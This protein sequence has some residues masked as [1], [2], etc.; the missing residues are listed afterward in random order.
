MLLSQS[1]FADFTSKPIVDARE[2]TEAIL[3]MSAEAV[4]QGPS[5]MA[6]SAA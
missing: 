6:Q 4:Q 3:W 2:G 1:R 5:D